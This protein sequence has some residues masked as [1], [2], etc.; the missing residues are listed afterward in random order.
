MNK[1]HIGYHPSKN[2]TQCETIRAVWIR[3]RVTE[4]ELIF[5]MT[6]QVRGQGHVINVGQIFFIA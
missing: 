2:I 4:G 3:A 6:L 1:M 5:D